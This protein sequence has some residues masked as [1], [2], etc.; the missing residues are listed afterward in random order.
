MKT[1]VVKFGGTSVSTK[2][3]IARIVSIVSSKKKDNPIVVVSALSGV[4]DLLLSISRDKKVTKEA[5]NRIRE[6]HYA[7]IKQYFPDKK[8]RDKLILEIDESISKIKK[9]STYKINKVSSDLLVANGEIM[10]SLIISE[11]LNHSGISARQVISTD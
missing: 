4:T 3:N 10:S 1:I 8:L 9:I 5:I 2:S 6:I 7:L 11:A